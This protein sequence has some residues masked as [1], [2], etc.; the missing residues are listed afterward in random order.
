MKVQKI[1]AQ[2][3]DAYILLDDDYQ[4]VREANRFARSL[5]A[6]NYSPN[7]IQTYLYALKSFYSFL[8]IKGWNPLVFLDDNRIT[9]LGMMLEFAIYLDDDTYGSKVKRM[10]AKP[11]VS[12]KTVNNYLSAV[13]SFYAFHAMDSGAFRLRYS[14]EDQGK[15][16]QYFLSE[17]T[18][19]RKSFHKSAVA[20]RAAPSD[21]EYVT[22]EDFDRLRAACG[23]Y[24]DKALIGVLFEGGLRIS[25]ALGLRLPDLKLED[26]KIEVVF[27]EDNENGARV[28]NYANRVCYVTSRVCSDIANMLVEESLK[29]ESN[30]VFLTMQGAQ[31]GKALGLDSAEKAI[32]RI[33]KRAGVQV[34]PH[35]FR[36]G[37]A[38]ERIEEGIDLEQLALLMGHKDIGSTRIYSHISRAFETEKIRPRVEQNFREIGGGHA[39]R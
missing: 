16:F 17:L 18:A 30:Y 29:Y 7:T 11:R 9:L 15:G 8:A 21:P 20:R 19:V 33:S 39:T 2:R 6:K 37:F 5:Y 26:E 13:M 32:A 24:R 14:E 22:R 1:A 12:E 4:P 28:K 3:R 34:H 35:M 23:T 36:H 38:V 10:H 25:E 31:A 27:R